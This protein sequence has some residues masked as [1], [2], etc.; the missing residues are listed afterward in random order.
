M[1]GTLSC[2]VPTCRCGKSRAG[3]PPLGDPSVFGVAWRAFR[4][5]PA[6]LLG[7]QD[8]WRSMRQRRGEAASREAPRPLQQR[9]PGAEPCS[10]PSLGCSRCLRCRCLR[11]C[12][13]FLRC[14]CFFLLTSL[15]FSSSESAL[16][17]LFQDR[18][19]EGICHV[20]SSARLKLLHVFGRYLRAGAPP[21]PRCARSCRNVPSGFGGPSLRS[22]LRL[23]R[24]QPR[25]LLRRRS[26]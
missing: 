25:P 14:C 4:T 8:H 6:E 21:A 20:S 23:A 17:F 12:F 13:R 18:F 7:Q 9:Q 2:R 16:L 11:C 1:L 15:A 26:S 10:Q 5:F 3:A 19:P 24:P 22:R